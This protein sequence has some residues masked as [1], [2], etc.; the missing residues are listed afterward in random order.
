MKDD[1]PTSYVTDRVQKSNFEIVKNDKKIK[2]IKLKK[3]TQS[4]KRK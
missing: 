3:R 2:P 4:T 1:F